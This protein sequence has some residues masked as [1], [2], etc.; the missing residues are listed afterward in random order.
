MT[1][2]AVLHESR[3]TW[4]R[5]EGLRGEDLESGRWAFELRRQI[6]V[7]YDRLERTEFARSIFEARISRAQYVRFVQQLL[8]IQEALE[9]SLD[10][11]A[12]LA[13]VFQPAQRRSAVLRRD[14]R[15]LGAPDAPGPLPGTIKSLELIASLRSSKPIALLGILYVRE[16]ARL[17]SVLLYQRLSHALGLPAELGRGLDAHLEGLT[18]GFERFH[19]FKQRLNDAVS[20]PEDRR[21]IVQVAR[22]QLAITEA[23]Y[24]D[25]ED[26][27]ASCLLWSTSA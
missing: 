12:P 21:R 7:D 18:E 8:L 24:L 9:E 17:S 25:L 14:L 20:D 22:L 1:A 5:E 13:Q 19:A 3:S 2:A 15:A 6:R 4:T 16:A 10:S 11:C 23:I 27:E 26:T